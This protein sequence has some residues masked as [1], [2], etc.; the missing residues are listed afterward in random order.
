MNCNCTYMLYSNYHALGSI[1]GWLDYYSS[2]AQKVLLSKLD[3]GIHYQ[4]N[5]CHLE[6]IHS[7]D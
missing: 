3:P 2:L 7:K 6:A 4:A 1:S 5:H